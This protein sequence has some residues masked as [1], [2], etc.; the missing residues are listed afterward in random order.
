MEDLAVKK[1][2]IEYCRDEIDST[3]THLREAM[4][5][6]QRAA[7]E[8]GPPKDRYDSFRTQLL[9]K[10]DMFAKQLSEAA[11]RKTV[12]DRIDP[13]QLL[14]TIQLGAVVVTNAQK[15]FI[16]IGLGRIDLNGEVY[17]AISPGVPVFRAMQG[18]RAGESY[19]FNGRTFKIEKVF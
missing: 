10:R 19:Q 17:Y 9:R 3:M 14:D 1:R 6:A 18:K 11:E 13:D 4:E 15:M 8:Y 7:N 16:S 12:L 5:D 2:L